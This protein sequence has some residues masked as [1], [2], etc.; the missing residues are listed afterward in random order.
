M[1]V[2]IGQPVTSRSISPATWK[3][4]VIK[5]L[6]EFTNLQD[7]TKHPGKLNGTAPKGTFMLIFSTA[8]L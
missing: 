4:K 5:V 8:V 7:L 2:N 1:L 3:D 6:T